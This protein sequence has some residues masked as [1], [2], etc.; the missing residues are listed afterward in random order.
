MLALERRN[1]SSSRALSL[2]TVNAHASIAATGLICVKYFNRLTELLRA[3]DHSRDFEPHKTQWLNFSID[4]V[5]IHEWSAPAKCRTVQFQDTPPM[6][7]VLTDYDHGQLLRRRS[8]PAGLTD[9]E[10]TL[11]VDNILQT[12]EE[13]LVLHTIQKV[14]GAL[15]DTNVF[16]V[17]V[18]SL[19]SG[20][21]ASTHSALTIPIP[22]KIVS[23]VRKPLG[24]LNN[25]LVYL[26]DDAWVCTWLI[27]SED[28]PSG[29]KRHFFIPRDRLNA[30]TL[31]LC[32]LM[33]N[34]I[35]LFPHY[36]EVVVIRC[37]ALLQ[38]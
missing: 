12:D 11:A 25:S 7:N 3:S 31:D 24:L 15:T 6:L 27:G 38:G 30:E 36:G 9:V 21:Q 5:S 22:A 4:R 37:A 28:D 19:S 26:N 20:T 14:A 32:Q 23:N 33:A 34:G 16:I 29:L 2:D 35:L 17:K 13:H 8:S 10:V 18:S 1:D